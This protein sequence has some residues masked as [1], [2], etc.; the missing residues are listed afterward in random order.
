MIHFTFFQLK[1]RW[2]TAI[3]S[4]LWLDWVHKNCAAAALKNETICF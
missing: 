4:G 2:S 3:A 1:G